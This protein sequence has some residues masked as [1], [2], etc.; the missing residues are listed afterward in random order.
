MQKLSVV[1]RG[2]LGLSS[3]ALFVLIIQLFG[4]FPSRVYT[5]IVWPAIIVVGL[6]IFI[7]IRY[8]FEKKEL[9]FNLKNFPLYLKSW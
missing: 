2:G 5:S 9:N 8:Q 4:F 3:G 1:S 6:V 7:I